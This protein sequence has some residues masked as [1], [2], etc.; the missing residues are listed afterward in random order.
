M[1]NLLNAKWALMDDT[2]THWSGKSGFTASGE[3]LPEGFYRFT[4][5]DVLFHS[6]CPDFAPVR[7]EEPVG[8]TPRPTWDGHCW[9]PTLGS[10]VYKEDRGVCDRVGVVVAH[11]HHPGEKFKRAVIQFINEPEII[12]PTRDGSG[13]HPAGPMLARDRFLHRLKTELRNET[14]DKLSA[15]E[16]DDL[17]AALHNF[18]TSELGVD[19]K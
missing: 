12:R 5:G 2:W 3:H 4:D 9:P 6:G 7:A 15:P 1:T 18:L 19:L 16:K 17:A 14:F 8:P 13:I 11:T 10:L